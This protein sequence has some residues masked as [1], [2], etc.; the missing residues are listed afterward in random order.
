V[1]LPKVVER[2]DVPDVGQ[3]LIP[4]FALRV[5]TRGVKFRYE[6]SSSP[7]GVRSDTLSEDRDVNSRRGSS[8]VTVLLRGAVSGL[9]SSTAPR[10]RRDDHGSSY[11][12]SQACAACC[13]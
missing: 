10:R 8:N 12:P 9:H 5:G 4:S 1:E 2:V 11:G 7:L 13:A 3:I 6:P